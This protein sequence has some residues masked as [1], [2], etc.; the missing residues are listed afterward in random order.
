MKPKIFIFFL[1]A[2]TFLQSC[3]DAFTTIKEIEIPE[4]KSKLAV[5][6]NLS[7]NKGDFSVFYSR[8]I[9][10]NNDYTPINAEI[11]I[12]ENGSP[13]YKSSFIGS[14]NK[15]FLE[16]DL[17][18]SISEGKEY[19][20]I[21]E[22]STYGKST[23]T[24]IV[25][26]KPDFSNLKYKK[27]GYIVSGGYKTDLLSFDINDNA[28][29]ENYY[30]IE[31]YGTIS[32]GNETMEQN[33]YLNSEDPSVKQ[34]WFRSKNGLIIADKNFNGEVTKILTNFE[35]YDEFK[36]IKLKIYSI[37]KDYYHFL[38][39]YNQ[40]QDSNGN[41]FAEPV[42]VH[43]NIENGYGLFEVNSSKEIVLD[44]E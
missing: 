30:L 23:A 28:S 36:K 13:F 16:K 5:F 18:K 34:F 9:T 26:R 20:L 7:E 38:L 2:I 17:G 43:N 19:T 1:F 41:P 29:D 31:S 14:D 25:P 27:D 10:N 11:T 40:Y 15:S 32:Q 12:L 44:I 39:S 8:I 33:L 37:T 42:N 6:A 4:H 24:Q 21:V 35:S 3:E 22:N